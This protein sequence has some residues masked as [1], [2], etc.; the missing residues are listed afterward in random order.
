M[1]PDVSISSDTKQVRAM[2]HSNRGQVRLDI[3]DHVFQHGGEGDQALSG[4]FTGDGITKI[5]VYRNGS[6]YI[7]YNGDGVWSEG[8]IHI[9]NSAQG[10]GAEGTAVVGDFDGDGIDNIGL[11]VNG[12]WHLD[13]TGDFKFDTMI[14]FGQAGD[15]PVVAD[16]DGDGIAQLAVYRAASAD[17]RITKAPSVAPAKAG[18]QYAADASKSTE[19]GDMPLGEEQ[20]SSEQGKLPEK[21]RRHGRTMRTPHSNAPLHRR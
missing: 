10:L 13:R 17:L 12:I 14:E 21:F 6:W 4:D 20:T 11:F 1:P 5:G 2:K 15:Q 8:D 7:D 3:I 16:F 19:Q 9:E 18:V